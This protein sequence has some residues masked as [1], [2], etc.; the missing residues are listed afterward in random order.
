VKFWQLRRLS[1]LE[2]KMMRQTTRGD[3]LPARNAVRF[4][5]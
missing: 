4:L 1:G 2:E 5:G 3:A